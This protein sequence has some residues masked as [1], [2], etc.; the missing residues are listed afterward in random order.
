MAE[1]CRLVKMSVFSDQ[2]TAPLKAEW[3]LHLDP[4][5]AVREVSGRLEA[6]LGDATLDLHRLAPEGGGLTWALHDVAK[7]EVEPFT[8]RKTQR[9]VY[10]PLFAG[11]DVTILTLLHARAAN[12][13]A[14]DDA[15]GTLRGRKAHVAWSRHGTRVTLEWDLERRKVVI[16]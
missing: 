16:R 9:V 1:G 12:D 6:T 5:A 3:L 10:E 15:K 7:P 14:L 11:H 4:K 8:F 2:M 13:P